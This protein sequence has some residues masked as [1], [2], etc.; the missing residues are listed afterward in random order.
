M[1]TNNAS[2][3]LFRIYKV[4]HLSG[5]GSSSVLKSHLPSCSMICE[6]LATILHPCSLFSQGNRIYIVS[7]I[8][9][10]KMLRF[11]SVVSQILQ[12]GRF[13]SLI[14]SKHF[15]QIKCEFEHSWMEFPKKTM[16]FLKQTYSHFCREEKCDIAHA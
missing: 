1:K 5:S 10:A 12:V 15:S 11:L 2:Q 9:T 6:V 14:F 3:M 8:L 4:V 16:L 13:I 7:L